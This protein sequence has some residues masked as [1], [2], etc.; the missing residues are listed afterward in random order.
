MSTSSYASSQPF[1]E[2]AAYP[3]SV[4]V[5]PAIEDRSRVGTFFR[6][7]LAIPHLILVGGPLAAALS[8]GAGSRHDQGFE[9]SSSF[10]IYGALMFFVTIIAWFAIVF[11]ASHPES[12]YRLGAHFL[13]WRVRANSYLMLLHDE[14]PPFGDGPYPAELE[15]TPPVDGDRDFTA[16]LLRI[17]FVIPQLVALWVLGIL[18]GLAT[19]VAW[20][21]IV[22]TGRYPEGLYQFSVGAL[23]WSTRVEAYMLLLTD[24]YP[25]FAIGR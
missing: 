16:V 19:I 20:F 10:G 8:W 2:A 23:R 3:V 15:L 17:V 13:R 1:G 24:S 11:T 5:V 6:L 22:F 14:Y 9:W 12:F 18:W 21:H 25:P 7:I 4:H